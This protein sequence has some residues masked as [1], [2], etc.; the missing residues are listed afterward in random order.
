MTAKTK[1]VIIPEYLRGRRCYEIFDDW[2]GVCYHALRMMPAHMRHIA[3]H[4]TPAPD[5]DEAAAHWQRLRGLYERQDFG[6]FQQAF[7]LLLG[8]AEQLPDVGDVLGDVYMAFA[9]PNSDRGQFFTPWHI[10]RLMAELIGPNERDVFDGLNAAIATG[11]TIEHIMAQSAL[12]A[13]L[14]CQTPDEAQAW[15]VQRVAPLAFACG[16]EPITVNDP[17]C[18]SGRML[19][20]CAAQLPAWMTQGAYVQFYGQDIDHTCVMMAQTN[21]MLYGLNGHAL[22]WQAA[23]AGTGMPAASAQPVVEVAVA[24]PEMPAIPL[25]QPAVTIPAAPTARQRQTGSALQLSLFD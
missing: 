17:A 4:G 14:G 10:Y 24:A 13:G 12:L 25:P 19:V 21:M 16:Y 6:E 7:H 18:G 5:D 15:F 8:S 3:E 20:A 23:L 11:D 2:L 22:R 9:Y 1:P